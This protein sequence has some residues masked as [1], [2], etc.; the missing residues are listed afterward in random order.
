MVY[1]FVDRYN[2]ARTIAAAT[3]WLKNN[4]RHFLSRARQGPDED[5]LPIGMLAA[6]VLEMDDVFGSNDVRPDYYVHT[7]MYLSSR[8]SRPVSV[9]CYSLLFSLPTRILTVPTRAQTTGLWRPTTLSSAYVHTT[10]IARYLNKI[11]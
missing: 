2:L 7:Y 9:T 3:L 11:V 10:H 4:R 6:Y 1:L 5:E 8:I